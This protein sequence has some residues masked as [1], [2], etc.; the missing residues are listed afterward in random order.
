[1]VE[2]KKDKKGSTWILTKTDMEGFHR[3]MNLTEEEL[4]ELFDILKI[5][6]L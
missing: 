2:I 6:E 1:M 4:V 5:I 3:Q